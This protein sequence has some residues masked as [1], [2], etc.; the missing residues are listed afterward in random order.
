MGPVD[1]LYGICGTLS[2]EM[3]VED[4]AVASLRF[5][6]GALGQI[7]GS[8]S[9]RPEQSYV[10]IFGSRS[11]VVLDDNLE[12]LSSWK[13]GENG[14][15]IT[16]NEILKEGTVVSSIGHD[17]IITDFVQSVLEDRTPFVDGSEGRK[18]LEIILGIYSSQRTGRKAVFPL[19]EE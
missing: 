15:K 12:I 1:Y 8:V 11:S 9:I 13:Q 3:E 7:V 6:N 17:S 14:K 5:K 18:S 10:G 16:I 19:V 2:H 4:T